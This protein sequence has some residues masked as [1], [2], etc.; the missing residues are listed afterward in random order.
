M[1][2]CSACGATLQPPNR[3]CPSCGAP[4][5]SDAMTTR[6]VASTPSATPAPGRGSRFAPGA[7]VAAR[8]RIVSLL[9][10]GGMGE[11]YRADDLTLDQQVALKFLPAGTTDA[12][13]ARFR[14]EVRIARQVS[15]P[16]VC[17]VYDLGEIN[18]AYF[19]SME[20][21]DGEDLAS[22][23]RRIGRL[24]TD[25]A[26]EIARKL[27]AG[28]AAAHEKGVL[29]RD[30]KPS[31]VMLN[32][33]GEVLLTDFGLAGLAG[34]IEGSEIRNGTPA[35]AAPEQLAGEEVTVRSDIYSLGLVLYE[36]FTG[37]MPFE[38]D[39]LAGLIRARTESTPVSLT[40][41]VRDLDPAVERVVLRCLD[42]KPARRP[43]SA[44]SVA[45]ALPGGDPL[46]AAL[47]AG[48]TPSPEMVAAA[49]E[50]R[51]LSQRIAIALFV[52]VIVMI[53]WTFVTSR[54]VSA[55]RTIAPPYSLD[56]LAQKARDTIQHAGYS[57][58]PVDEIGGFDWN[59]PYLD[60]ASSHSKK[61]V[62]WPSILNGRP[63]ALYYWHRQSQSTLE[64]LGVHDDW[65][66]AGMVDR[67]D[68]PQTQT[69]MASVLLDMRGRLLAFHAIPGEE[70]KP[71]AGGAAPAADYSALFSA[72][73]L[74]PAKLT[75]AE[76]TTNYLEPADS[77]A[78]WTGTW[79][80]TQFPL[81]VEAA[82]MRGKPVTFKLL[83]PWT[84][85]SREPEG[86]S[87]SAQ[88]I[89]NLFLVLLSATTL[90]CAPLLARANV[91]QRRGDMRGAYRLAVA[92]FLL[93][94]GLWVCRTHFAP[95]LGV[96]GNFLLAVCTSSFYALLLW[97]LYL[98]LEPFVRR[99]WPQALISWTSV[100]S[101]HVKDPI[102]GRDCLIGLIVAAGLTVMNLLSSAGPWVV[103]PHPLQ[104]DLRVLLG[105]RATVG[106]LFLTLP[107]GI[108]GALIFLMMMFLLRVALR[109]Q[110]LAGVAFAVLW[111]LFNYA[112]NGN[113]IGGFVGGFIVYA[114][115]AFVMLQ[116]GLLPMVVAIIGANTLTYAQHGASWY[117]GYT[118]FLIAAII[119]LSVWGL[120]TAIGRHKPWYS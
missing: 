73:D 53:A 93:L 4:A 83:G 89:Q 66:T 9:G 61:P 71:L 81:R 37:R 112:S 7:I 2:Q 115:F 100:L 90:I 54:R 44:I 77:R 103:N 79:P 114:A 12:A 34:Q 58:S 92:M 41:I 111:G 88:Q 70:M 56:V 39:T 94:M 52:A 75:P 62:N 20:Y 76:P 97:T 32:G 50:G 1:A 64:T 21:V 15:H 108:R 48:E 55:L 113:S 110:W 96:F 80:G 23:L 8:Y 6:T 10:K 45:A 120:F 43:P 38:S 117:F 85:P 78:A 14:N 91:R 106:V 69:G 40:T 68:P 99:R 46:A 51:G 60:Y 31:N 30:L 17:R 49:G 72:A 3:F 87:S 65:L 119:A 109:N 104:G 101:G 116:W 107:Q 67:Y 98:G 95:D 82:A 36:I 102:V 5:Q 22:L 86:E 42:A 118:L 19:L 59:S 57:A 16:N 28:L 29:H 27:C 74:D 13:I 35:Y 105:L 26:L 11:V 25:K 84:V 63:A 33:R 18:G 47:A 24:P